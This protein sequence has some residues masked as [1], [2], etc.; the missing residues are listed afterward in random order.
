MES[1]YKEREKIILRRVKTQGLR[2]TVTGLF[3]ESFPQVGG[4]RKLLC[5][6]SSRAGEQEEELKIDGEGGPKGDEGKKEPEDEENDEQSYQEA[7]VELKDERARE[8][9]A[10][11]SCDKFSCWL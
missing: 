4:L 10:Q 9:R 5:G 8:F 11:V 7:V 3:N 6:G 2:K 1:T